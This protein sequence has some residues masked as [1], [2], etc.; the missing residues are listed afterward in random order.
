MRTW[1]GAVAEAPE[2]AVGRRRSRGGRWSIGAHL[3]AVVIA[4]VGLLAGLGSLFTAGSLRSARHSARDATRFRA[5]LAAKAVDDDVDLAKAT[6]AGLA[7]DPAASALVVQPGRCDLTVG[8]VRVFGVAHVDLVR[9]D[10][11]VA[12]SSLEPLPAGATHSGASWVATLPTSTTTTVS[13]TFLDSLSGQPAIA[14]LVPILDAHGQPAGA[15]TVVAGVGDLAQQLS[16]RFGGAE[17]V[18]FAVVDEATGTVIAT[19]V[20]SSSSSSS[21]KG[22]KPGGAFRGAPSGTLSGSDLVAG[23]GW[24][25][26]AFIPTGTAL[27][28]IRSALW[29]ELVLALA[30]IGLLIG[31]FVLLDWR[32]AA[33]LRLLRAAI[34][35]AGRQLTPPPLAV[36]GPSEIIDLT[37][38]FNAMIE[39]R[40][41]YE[42]S[43]AR[44]AL[45]DALTGLPSLA[46]LREDLAYAL[47]R[48]DRS[49]TMVGV[50]CVDLDRFTLI[51]STHG[52]QTG[53]QVLI[54][55]AG[56]L[57][58]TLRPSDALTRLGADEFVV[59]CE[60]LSDV[61][62]AAAC[63]Q[64][65][66]L[67]LSEPLSVDATEVTVTASI[68][69]A[70]GR[71]GGAEDLLRDA[72]AAV[73][74]AK[75]RGGN[76]ID[77]FDE[78]LRARVSSR[79]EIA[80]Q[81][82]GALQR[83]ELWLAYQPIVDLDTARI[84]GSE[85]L[86]RWNPVSGS[87]VFPDQFIPVAEETGLIQPI[88]LYVLEHA[89]QQA[90]TWHR[91]GL[92]GSVS[93]N[94]S[95]RQLAD[96][97]FP[98]QVAGILQRTAMEPA[99][100][101][102]ELTE[103]TLM[104]DAPRAAQLLSA[105]KQHGVRLSIDDFGTGYSSLAYLQ[106][107]P[108]DELKI[109]RLFISALPAAAHA[110]TLVGAIIAMGGALGLD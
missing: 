52:H 64:R 51:N 76:C 70:I 19:S 88:G 12:C 23:A 2:S 74:R 26:V 57:A 59:V 75:G 92:V 39:V 68:G 9:P 24:R 73:S 3:A 90:V 35:Q 47:G 61:G 21:S 38:D 49:H 69:I 82:A 63:A 100:L 80:G 50:L 108:V 110:R 17:H 101:T 14:V 55:M 67:A 58:G 83:D 20:P 8:A 40:T 43:L 7:H 33:P 25:V 54:A 84:R 34:R 45:H 16:A 53:D 36:T 109:D 29:H 78:E 1:V 5:G 41:E 27:M 32:L 44:R 103:S 77:V 72:D 95:G 10:G 66:L 6:A 11:S 87:A 28:A 65:L 81:L 105:L 96:P 4:V 94:V 42:T 99:A 56:R 107:F 13:G 97:T 18:A 37:R 98:D 106:L 85:I 60:G 91:H 15:A 31:L 86:L 22:A 30:S 93:V 46:L 62:D 89:C 102:L 104:T 71:G 48:A 79:L